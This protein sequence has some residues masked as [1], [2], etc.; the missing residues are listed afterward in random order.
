MGNDLQTLRRRCEARLLDLA[1]PE[2]FDL[3]RFC[4]LL[5]ERRG[6][7]LHVRPVAAGFGPHGFWAATATAD[8]VFYEQETSPLHRLHIIFHEFAHIICAHHPPSLEDVFFPAD[9]FASLHPETIRLLF[10]RTA[11]STEEER[12]AE[13]LATMLLERVRNQPNLG[14]TTL[15]VETAWLRQRIAAEH[16]GEPEIPR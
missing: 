3:D 14:S 11:Y 2:P 5:A 9:L 8:Y 6:R 12:E 1:L 7:P 15:D 10:Q 16:T 13:I 4:S